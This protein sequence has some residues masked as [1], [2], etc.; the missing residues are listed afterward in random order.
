MKKLSQILL[1]WWFWILNKNDVVATERLN[2]CIPCEHRKFV[3]CAKCGCVLQAKVRLPEE[4]CPVGKW[5]ANFINGG[6]VKGTK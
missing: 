6:F 3:T 2:I 4:A 1:G 5:P